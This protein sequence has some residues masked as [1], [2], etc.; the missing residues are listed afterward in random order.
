[1]SKTIEPVWPANQFKFFTSQSLNHQNILIEVWHRGGRWTRDSFLGEV[2]IPLSLLQDS[3]IV[4]NSFDLIKEPKKKSS[5]AGTIKIKLEYPTGNAEQK[6][7][8]EVTPPP[9]KKKQLKKN[10]I[11]K[12][13]LDEAVFPLWLKPQRKKRRK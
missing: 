11:F 5:G 13:N 3:N 9:K 7:T 4:V 6:V 8:P 10:T 2:K 1:M 12:R